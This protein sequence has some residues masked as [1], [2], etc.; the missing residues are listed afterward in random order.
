[1]SNIHAIGRERHSTLRWQH[2]TSYNFAATEGLTPLV[3][4]EL[5]AAMQTMPIA[6]L[7]TEGSALI[8]FAMQGLAPGKNLFVAGN[9]QWVGAYIP[10]AL[11]AYPFSLAKTADHQQV[12]CIDEDSGLLS[13]SSGEPFW[14]EA[15][16]PA[17]GVTEVFQMLIRVEANRPVTHKICLLLQKHQ[18]IKPW[19]LKVK[20]ETSEQAVEGLFCI[21]ET[22]L[23]QLPAEALLELRNTGALLCAYCQLL[24]MQNIQTLGQMAAIHAKAAAPLPSKNRNEMDLSFLE[25]RDLLKFF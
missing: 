2:N 19:P 11:R 7:E 18:L 4:Q 1:M 3:A 16:Q 20:N 12:L 24:S 21:D 15:G 8:P 9:G 22:A 6:F 23:N 5:P 13:Q 14:D 10:A 25:G 17:T